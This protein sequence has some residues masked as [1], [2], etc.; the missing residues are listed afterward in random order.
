MLGIDWQEKTLVNQFSTATFSKGSATLSLHPISSIGDPTTTLPPSALVSLADIPWYHCVPRRV[1]RA[2][3]CGV[4]S[5]TGKHFE[6]RRGWIV[7]KIK[8]LTVLLVADVASHAIM[9]NHYHLVLRVD[10]ERAAGWSDE[11]VLT[12]GTQMFIGPV[13][14][15]HDL[16][17]QAGQNL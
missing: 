16:L 11:G 10:A 9:S 4:D 17:L 15:Q 1:R 6:H 12:R 5:A 3:P 13:L 14:V 7:D 8:E 2:Y